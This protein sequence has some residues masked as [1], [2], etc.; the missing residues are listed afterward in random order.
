MA[1]KQFECTSSHYAVIKIGSGGFEGGNSGDNH[2]PLGLYDVAGPS[3]YFFRAFLKF[4]LDFS[5]VVSITKAELKVRTSNGTHVGK[6]A[7][8]MTISRI[9]SSWTGSG[10]SEGS[11]TGSPNWTGQ[12]SVTSSGQVARTISKT[13]DTWNTLDITDIVQAWM[14]GSANNGL[15]L[16]MT[17]ESYP[18]NSN[19][20]E[21]NELR[22]ANAS[23]SEPYILL[24]YV[25]NTLPSAPTLSSP[26][27]GSRQTTATPSFS[28]THNDADDDAC[29]SYDLQVSTDSG[30]SSV[31]H[32]NASNQTTGI[33]GDSI[34]RTYAGTALTRG[35]TYYWRCRTND[36]TGDGTWS[37]TRSF[38]YNALP[39]VTKNA[40]A[41][42]A[43]ATISNLSE[44]AVWSGSEAKPTMKFTPSDADG[45]TITK[46]RLRIYDAAAAGNMVYDS[47]EVSVSY[48][49]GVQQTVS[50]AFGIAN[51]T[52]R[53]WTIDVYD[54][55][56]WAGES[57][58]TAFK[59][60]WAQGLYEFDTGASGSNGWS[61]SNGATTEQVAILFRSATS[62]GGT[63][64]SGLTAFSTAIGSVTTQRWVQV[65]VRLS[66]DSAGTDATLA[67]MTFTYFGTPSVPDD[68]AV[69]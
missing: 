18:S 20:P 13:T 10:G 2:L 65:L 26:A 9:T 54:G 63:G 62:S 17:N 40:P 12:P 14:D 32:W 30:F 56:E 22:S 45:D 21:A 15:R 42:S 23:G 53:W 57:S 61:F 55:Y 38:T 58:R 11:S 52:E 1:T 60:R 27:N 47:G 25:D 3:W 39:T 35:V 7:T 36:G 29:A 66:T 43:L 6:D 49:S 4:A 67:D 19:T 37:S 64:A 24:T 51:G 46:Y 5:D 41:A 69:S 28:F 59:M 44:L 16:K 31:T 33:S 8:S 34:T 68:W 48:S 50:V